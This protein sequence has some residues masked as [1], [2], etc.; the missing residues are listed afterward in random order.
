MNS[1]Q[2]FTLIELMIVISIIGILSTMALPSYQDRV[3]RVQIKEAFDVATFA[4][5]E[6][7]EFYKK[8]GKLPKNNSEVGLP[9]PDKIVG[10]YLV[11]LRVKD[12]GAIDLTLGNRGNKNIKGR[13]I[14][15]RPAI[16]EEY[17]KVPIAWVDGY[18]SVPEGMVVKG[19]NDTTVLVRHLP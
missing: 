4:K 2:G 1:K 12:G 19:V 13:V 11:S 14:T 3:I 6:V 15:L 7:A 5:E 10:N 9:E 8:K 17:P 18:A 16:V